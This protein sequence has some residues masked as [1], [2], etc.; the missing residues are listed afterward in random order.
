MLDLLEVNPSGC[1]AYG[2]HKTIKLAGLGVTELTG[3][4]HDR[5]TKTANGCGKTSLLNT[6]CH[7]LYGADPLGTSDTQMMNSVWG[8]GMWGYLKYRVPKGLFRIVMC[9]KWSLDYPDP[10]FID[11]PAQ[12][13]IQGDKYKGTD[14]YF[15][16]WDGTQWVDRRKSK[17]VETRKSILETLPI[18]YSQ[19]L[20]TSYMAQTKGISFVTGRNKD[21]M[22]IIS[23]LLDMQIWDTANKIARTRLSAL[24]E[25]QVKLEGAI[26]G[27]SAALLMLPSILSGIQLAQMDAT[28]AAVEDEIAGDELTIKMLQ[29]E[30]GRIAAEILNVQ[31]RHVGV[32]Q[33]HEASRRTLDT[34]NTRLRTS[35]MELERDLA[36]VQPDASFDL[37]ALYH[38]QGAAAAKCQSFKDQIDSVHKIGTVCDKCGTA[39]NRDATQAKIHSLTTALSDARAEVLNIS[40]LIETT[41]IEAGESLQRKRSDIRVAFKARMAA[42]EAA[43]AELVRSMLKM[44]GTL[45]AI[46]A[47]LPPLEKQHAETMGEES[48]CKDRLAGLRM[49]LAQCK[50]RKAQNAQAVLTRAQAQAAIDADRA[51]LDALTQEITALSIVIKGMSDRGI[52]AH[53]F[54]AI[55]ATLNE[56]VKEYISVLT[57]GQVQVWFTPFREKASAK[58]DADVIAEV[59][60]L[61][62]EGPKEEVELDQYSGAEKQQI[63]LAIICA[64]WRLASQQGGGTNILF[65]DEIFGSFDGATASLAIRLIEK[66]RESH[67]GTIVVVTHD[68][69]VQQMLK[70]D[71]RWVLEKRNHVSSLTVL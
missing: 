16:E 21:R 71:T 44:V 38:K 56:L 7:L 27:K 54:G 51:Q 60:I 36:N 10:G 62:R 41:K 9:R 14:I 25:Q 40:S 30:R 12:I 4:N 18:S 55:I 34:L 57:D 3:I 23:E 29:D 32:K 70:Y 66:L 13:H 11:D 17:T 42:D 45:D 8:K 43:R 53:K 20:T 26:A 69:K 28:M 63:T 24:T 35:E 64:F 15:D 31:M 5:L 49:S 1:F 22:Q 39:Q 61:V 67:F 33:E 46:E 59:S 48:T 19:F 50:A 6:V 65:L 47:E 37:T 2:P 58:T 68:D 52:K